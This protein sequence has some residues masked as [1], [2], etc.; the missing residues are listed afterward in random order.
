ML[1]IRAALAIGAAVASGLVLL[2]AVACGG[3]DPAVPADAPGID[4]LPIDAPPPGEPWFDEGLRRGRIE[5]VEWVGGAAQVAQAHASFSPQPTQ[6][7][8]VFYARV[9]VRHWQQE[10]M[11]AGS[12]RLLENEPVFC[13]SCAGLC[14][15]PEVCEPYPDYASA[16][17]LTFDGLRGPSLTL[18]P[19]PFYASQGQLPAD[20]VA[21]DATLTVTATGAA[22]PAFTVATTAVP[23]LDPSVAPI[24]NDELL[25]AGGADVTVTWTAVASADPTARVR[26]TLD[27]NN[28]GHGQPYAAV[29]E[30]DAADVG[31]LTIPAAMI[32]A[33]PPASR[34]E[35]CVGSDCPVSTLARYRR[36]ATLVDG[37]A[38]DLV[39][40]SQR[41]FWVVK[42]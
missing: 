9:A 8:F 16:G 37:V 11:R 13:S 23:P 39:V 4:A 14:V 24:D 19:S 29:I 35:A 17:D 41:A 22:V 12:C 30:C 18:Q 27:A 28:V 32:D 34:Q 3:G 21:D 1:R 25:L 42:P 2:A 5:L 36:G 20:A 33:F 38:V 15:A 6:M 10:T 31:A 26:L 7:R 40:A